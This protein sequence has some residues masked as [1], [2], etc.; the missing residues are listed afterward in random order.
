MRR[1]IFVQLNGFDTSLR[2]QADLEFCA[3]AFEILGMSSIYIPKIWVQMRL[4]GISTGRW[5]PRIKGNWESYIA[6]RRLGLKRDPVSFFVIKFG[7]KLKQF[8]PSLNKTH[9]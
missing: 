5:G 4:G 2:Y 7:K 6:L 1:S 9:I 3:R 8:F